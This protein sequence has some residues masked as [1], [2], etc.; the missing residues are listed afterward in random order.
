M[1]I[2]LYFVSFAS[3][4]V[5]FASVIAGA[6]W[7]LVKFVQAWGR[8]FRVLLQPPD[9]AAIKTRRPIDM[10]AMKRAGQ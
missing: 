10:Q 4:A 5:L 9:R 8:F 2:L 6:L 1:S 7:L 3:V